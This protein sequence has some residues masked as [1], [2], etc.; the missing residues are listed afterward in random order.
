MVAE[1]ESRDIRK[2][3][4]ALQ[5]PLCMRR[6]VAGHR[7]ILF[8]EKGISRWKMENGNSRNWGI[9]GLINWKWDE[10]FLHFGPEINISFWA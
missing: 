1:L 10:S 9:V 6:E 5:S 3:Q 7:E 4:L 2:R 8:P